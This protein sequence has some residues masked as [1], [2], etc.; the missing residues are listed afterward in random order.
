MAEEAFSAWHFARYV[1]YVAVAGRAAYDLPMYV[2]AWLYTDIHDRAGAWPSGGPTVHVLDIWKSAAPHIA[3]LAPD[4]YYPK[5]HKV[6]TQ[7]SRDDNPLFVPETGFVPYHAGFAFLTFAEFNGLGFSP[8]GID[9]A[10][11]NGALAPE[12]VEFEDTYRVLAPLLPLISEYQHT[13]KMH[14][15]LQGYAD[16]EDFAYRI[17]IGDDVAAMVEFTLPF[18][19][20]KTRGRGMIIELAPDDLI[21]AGA[22]FNVVFRAL[23]GPP[24]DI[25]MLSLEEG[26]FRGLDWVHERRLNGDELHVRLPEKAKTLRARLR[27]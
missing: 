20:G 6:C 19:I 22:G 21:I 1:D 15:I 25:Q 8:F 5:Y 27:I 13:G 10:L 11:V 7:Y 23:E 2:N 24:R 18:E 17:P 3:L 26:T 4:I 9:H 12:A 16:G 14:S